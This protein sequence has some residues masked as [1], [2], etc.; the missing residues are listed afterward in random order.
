MPHALSIYDYPQ[1]ILHIDGDAFFASC[2]M[3]KNPALKGKPVITGMER[4][5]VSSLSYEAKARGV[6]RAMSFSEVKRVCPDAIFLPSDYETYSLYSLRMYEIVR[7]YTPD[8]EEY[9]IDE[10]F[11]DLT[12]LQRPLNMN[13]EKIAEKIKQELDQELGMTF[14]VGLAPTKV[15]AK[16]AS[17][18]KKPSGLTLIPGKTIHH[19][20]KDL[21][22]SKVWGIGPQT[23]AYLN[24]LGIR[25]AL[26]FTDKDEDW[27]LHNLTK[28]HYEIWQELHGKSVCGLTIGQKTSYQSISKTRTFTPPS[29][30]EKIVFSE[31]SKNIEN[32][33]IKARRHNLVS[34]KIF[35]FLKTQDFR[36]HSLELT[37]A[38][39]TNIP[40]EIINLVKDNFNVMF[41]PRSLYRA[42][43]VV[44][45]NLTVNKNYQLD[46]FSNVI[47]AEKLARVFSSFDELAERYG[48]HTLFLGSSFLAMRRKQHDNT[49]GTLSERKS[50]LLKGEN[51][52]QRIGLPFLGEVV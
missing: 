21:S 11:A 22:V 35:L 8:V 23:T 30:D 18:W 16:V 44:L 52:R 42:T 27:V 45:V 19:F 33:C 43:G 9:S 37:L 39:A 41:R 31:L 14:S 49:R 1:A 2:E 10:C 46:L 5:I 29:S 26:E 4:G 20:L 48:K 7:R 15:L 50:K 47:K 40:I 6:K 17:K 28:P 13:Y 32:A 25:T 38:R 12:G 51:I 3:V 36:F 24:K 34:Q